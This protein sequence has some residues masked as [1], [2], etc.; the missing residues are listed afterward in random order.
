MSLVAHDITFAY[1]QASPLLRGFSLEVEPGE[2]VALV[3]L[4]GAGKTTLCRI[5][6]GVLMPQAGSV[7][8]DGKGFR[9]YAGC[10]LS[11]QL[12][13][14]HPELA[15]D[16]RMRMGRSLA[17]GAVGRSVEEALAQAE[18]EGLISAF[19]IRREWYARLPHELSGG[20]LMRFCIARALLAHPRYLICDEMTAMLDA[21]TQAE[22]WHAVLE[23]ARERDMGLVVVSHTPALIDCIA[24]RRVE[25]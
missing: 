10:A 8:V 6:A 18:S 5:L 23:I 15:F 19:G 1:P 3:A 14:Q 4:S 2:R 11:V 25:L 13:A 20:E 22:V 17:E 16:P 7:T 9:A 21:L 12:I 24:T